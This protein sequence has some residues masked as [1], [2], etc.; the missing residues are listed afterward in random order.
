MRDTEL[1]EPGLALSRHDSGDTL[2]RERDS[3][4]LRFWARRR[5]RSR[6]S[7]RHLSTVLGEGDIILFS[8]ADA[9]HGCVQCVT[10]SPYDHCALVIKAGACIELMEL[11]VLEA[12]VDGV[13]KIPVTYFMEASRFGRFT[14]LLSIVRSTLICT[15]RAV[16]LRAQA[17]ALPLRR[18]GHGTSVPTNPISSCV[19][20]W[21]RSGIARTAATVVVPDEMATQRRW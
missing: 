8:S 16:E 10:Q 20:S 17:A 21:L 5:W 14:A 15:W 7:A 9:A 2:L 19:P 13:G 4:E 11:C 1:A 6:V 3:A 18:R 12:S